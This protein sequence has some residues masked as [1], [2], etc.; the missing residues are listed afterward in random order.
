M[1]IHR[2][3]ITPAIWKSPHKR[4]FQ[5]PTPQKNAIRQSYAEGH[6]TRRFLQD[7]Y[8]L[9]QTIIRR[10]L[11]YP[12]ATR[13]RIGRIGPKYLLSNAEVDD[14]KTYCAKSW[15]HRILTYKKLK[16]ALGLNCSVKTLGKRMNQRGFFR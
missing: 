8:S 7:K 15:E 13:E 14:I 4:G 10:I 5:I 6:V 11:F 1:G 12:L 2:E 3:P 16:E 9:G